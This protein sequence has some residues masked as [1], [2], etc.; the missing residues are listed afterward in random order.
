VSER[1][2]VCV[3]GGGEAVCIDVLVFGECVALLNCLLCCFED[4]SFFSF[5]TFEFSTY[6]NWGG[7]S[8]L[9]AF[10]SVRSSTMYAVRTTCLVPF[11]GP[12]WENGFQ[13]S[14][15]GACLPDRLLA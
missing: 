13:L 15:F 9:S 8:C 10:L 7:G 1:V 3:W 11:L 12:A 14:S 5:K 6:S 4:D 2:R